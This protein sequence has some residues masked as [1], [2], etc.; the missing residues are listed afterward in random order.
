M[1]GRAFDQARLQAACEMLG[2]DTA[3]D[4]TVEPD[5]TTPTDNTATT[6]EPAAPVG[7]WRCIV[8]SPYVSIDLTAEI[9]EDKTLNGQ[10]TIIYSGTYK[11]YQVSGSGNWVALPPDASSDKWLFHFRMKPS[12][13]AIFSWFANPTDDPNHM[14]NKFVPNDKGHA[15]ITRCARET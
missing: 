9:A 12:N 13:H 2:D 3:P 6:D 14:Y 11:T 1:A 4:Q 15:V 7:T 10:G 8:E 5:N